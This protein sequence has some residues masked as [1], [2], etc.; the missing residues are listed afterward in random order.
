MIEK[1]NNMTNE[2]STDMGKVYD[3]FAKAFGEAD[4]LPTWRYVGKAAMEKVLAPHMKSGVTFLDM[5]SASARVEA[6]VL[7]PGGVE[8][9]DITGVEISPDQVEMAKHR[10]PGATF[11]VGNVADPE[12][13]A[14]HD[15]KFG[16]VFSHMVFEHLN[17]EQLR[18]T[19]MNAYRLL[20]PGGTFAFVVTHPDKMTDLNGDL[21]QHYGEFETSA[22]WGGILHNWRRSVADTKRIVESAGFS[23]ESVEDVAFPTEPERGLSPEDLDEFTKSSEKYRRYPA[24][25]LTVSAKKPE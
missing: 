19:S 14:G 18:Q 23:V 11:I 5:G 9:K 6:G 15:G 13:L 16:V 22:P 8:A 2:T 7:L 10:I 4:K 17:D 20:K 21:V 12:V 24:I 25:R 3:E 1:G